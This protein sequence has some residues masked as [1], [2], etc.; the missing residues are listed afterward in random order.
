M[1]EMTTFQQ[2]NWKIIIR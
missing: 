2:L 1:P